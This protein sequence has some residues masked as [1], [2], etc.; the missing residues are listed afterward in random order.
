MPCMPD[1]LQP[2]LVSQ[3]GSRWDI[4]GGGLPSLAPKIMFGNEDPAL[5][6]VSLAM[7]VCTGWIPRM[8]EVGSVC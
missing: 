2:W 4:D 8:Y 6:V 3:V 7:Q 5:L 1:A